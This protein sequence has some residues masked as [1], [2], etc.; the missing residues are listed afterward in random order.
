MF[1]ELIVEQ[2]SSWAKASPA[3]AFPAVCEQ[4]FVGSAASVA[5]VAAGMATH[6]H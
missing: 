1:E 2:K 5:A 4:G 6:E 3:E